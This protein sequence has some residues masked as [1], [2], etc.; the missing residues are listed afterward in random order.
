MFLKQ[1]ADYRTILWVALAA[2]F[3]AVQYTWPPTARVLLPLTCYFGIACGTITHNHNHCA[4]FVGRRMNHAFGHIL[5]LFYGYPTI[6]W[7]PTHNQNH[8]RLVNRPGDAT[9]TWR[10]TNKHNLWVA[11]TYFFV[12]SYFQS[13]PIKQY[14]RRAK[15]HN[16][17]LYGRILFQ[18][19]IWLGYLA[20]MLGLGLWLHGLR[21]GF[22]VWFAAVVVPPFCS[23]SM[24]MFFNYVQ[25][26][27]ADAWSERDHSRNFTGKIFNY[28]FFN[29][30]YHT[31]HHDHP[32][33]HW[34]LLPA[35]HARIAASVDPRLNEGNLAWFLVK[36]YVLAWIWPKYGTQQLGPEPLDAAAA[37]ALMAPLSVPSEPLKPASPTVVGLCTDSAELAD[38][39]HGL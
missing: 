12:S 21:T 6:M 26:V 29:N 37:A 30:G 28:L 16:R 25:H 33:M 35:A 19:S 23:L 27:H 4:T 24:I 13:E 22:L 20:L 31:I 17:P 36:Q 2:A 1:S 5:T 14:I 38:A 3:V 9:I 18:Y 7:I 10:Y 8:H 34:S 32:G 39:A 11:S 15:L